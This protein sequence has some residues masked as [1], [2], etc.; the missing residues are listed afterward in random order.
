MMGMDMGAETTSE[1]GRMLRESAEAKNATADALAPRIAV[2][3][4]WMREALETGAKILLFGNG[5]SM[6][7]ANHIA[8]E[9]VG[10]Y[11]KE[12][13]ALPAM[14]LSEPSLLSCIAN[15]FGYEAIF[16]RQ[17]EAWAGCGDIVIGLSTSGASPNVVAALSAARERGAR[18]V[19]MTGAK[20]EHA[21]GVADLVLD[22]PSTNTPRIQECPITIGHILCELIEQ[23]M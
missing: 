1:I 13:R 4:G 10:R 11:R 21:A 20:G 14:S 17:V 23:D 5:G 3:A 2:L 19:L 18:T 8:E 9:L 22:V 7:D 16:R 15:D 12:R 6:C